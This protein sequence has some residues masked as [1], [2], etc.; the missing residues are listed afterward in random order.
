MQR[1]ST[2][3][4]NKSIVKQVGWQL[5][6]SVLAWRRWAFRFFPR[7]PLWICLPHPFH[8]QHLIDVWEWR[9]NLWPLRSLGFTNE[10]GEMQMVLFSL[11][12]ISKYRQGREESV[13][14][15][16]L[17]L[18]S[19]ACSM[20]SNISPKW[21]KPFQVPQFHLVKSL[22]QHFSKPP[23]G[24]LTPSSELAKCF[25]KGIYLLWP[26]TDACSVP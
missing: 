10:K 12:D 23:P 26:N 22:F 7:T 16:V 6:V 24:V 4:I 5:W 11:K 18:A 13:Q 3:G 17:F 1:V 15:T 19:D 9:V 14:Q 20:Q 21:N 25:Q 8:S 2:K